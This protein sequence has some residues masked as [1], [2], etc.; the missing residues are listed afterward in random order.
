MHKQLEKKAALCWAT[1]EVVCESKVIYDYAIGFTSKSMMKRRAQYQLEFREDGEA[2][3][4]ML[5]DCLKRRDALDIEEY[6]ILAA[7]KA[8]I[9]SNAHEKLV[10]YLKERKYRRSYGGA[11][12]EKAD[13]PIHGVYMAFWRPLHA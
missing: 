1:V 11:S 3:M 7:Q 4:V 5:I 2:L 9:K 12:M 13:Q 6:L 8:N 10:P